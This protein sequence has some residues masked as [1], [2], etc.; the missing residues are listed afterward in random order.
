MIRRNISMKLFQNKCKVKV[1]VAFNNM[2]L[3]NVDDPPSD[4]EVNWSKIKDTMTFNI[5]S[6]VHPPS[7]FY[8]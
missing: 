8:T 3:G 2:A 6:M 1:S 4:F 5:G 7:V